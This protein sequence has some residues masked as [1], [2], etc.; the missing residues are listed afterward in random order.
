[1][2]GKLIDVVGFGDN[3]AEMRRPVIP[4]LRTFTRHG[5]S[6]VPVSDWFPHVGSVIDEIAVVRSMWCNEGNHFPA[7]IETLHRAPGPSSSITR[8]SGALVMTC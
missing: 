1:M 5:K 4:C 6:G 2:V 3:Q 8:R 7:V